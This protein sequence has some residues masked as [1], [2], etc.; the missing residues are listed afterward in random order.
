MPVLEIVVE[1]YKVTGFN[2]LS[3]SR[4]NSIVNEFTG[5]FSDLDAVRDAAE[6]LQQAIKATGYS[7]MEV[8]VPPQ[9]ISNRVIELQVVGYVISEITV[10]G[11]KYF[12]EKNIRRSLPHLVIGESPNT[13]AIDLSLQVANKSPRK[14]TNLKFLSSS[15]EEQGL[16]T[17]LSVSDQAPYQFFAWANNTGTEATGDFRLGVGAQHA[18]VFDRDHA[19]T[20]TY[21]TSPDQQEKVGQIGASYRVPFYRIGGLLDLL[22]AK[23]DIDTGRVAGGFDVSGAGQ[24]F[25][26]SFTKYFQKG[27]NYSK[28]VVVGLSDKLFEN[29]IRAAIC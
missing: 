12:S 16:E 26:T 19:V 25:G 3:E 11:N 7:L 1:G 10:E 28:T 14:R 5:T 23:S 27:E 13:K 15:S 18:N 17:T 2:P 22:Y 21:T 29:N 9:P 24:V 6:A 8:T 20:L 4:T